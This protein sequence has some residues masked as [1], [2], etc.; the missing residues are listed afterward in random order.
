MTTIKF[1]GLPG[2]G[3]TSIINLLKTK[4]DIS[5]ES[6]ITLPCV[7]LY[8]MYT[9]PKQN[10]TL[11]HLKLLEEFKKSYN[12]RKQSTYSYYIEHTPFEMFEFFCL[13]NVVAGNITEYGYRYLKEK[14]FP[15]KLR[16]MI[17]NEQEKCIYIYI[18]ATPETCIKNMKERNRDGEFNMNPI[19]FF[20]VYWFII[21]HME[22]NF[23]NKF[24]VDYEE[25]NF[26]TES[27][28]NFLQNN[29]KVIW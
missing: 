4:I 13:A 29:V 14:S 22:N 12:E 16:Q 20:Q 23:K 21:L 28:L 26:H 17:D 10:T 15:I 27:I 7:D 19:I 3:K 11:Y 18:N 5:L 9:N 24:V 6:N 1:I 2:C 8:H 25:N